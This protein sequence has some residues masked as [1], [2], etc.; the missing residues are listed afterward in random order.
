MGQENIDKPNDGVAWR[1][2]SDF[3]SALTVG[4][5]WN[6]RQRSLFL[7]SPHHLHQTGDNMGLREFLRIP[8]IKINRRVRSKAR[9][10]VSSIGGPS[11]ENQVVPRPAVSAPDLGIGGSNLPTPSPLTSTG[12]ELKGMQTDVSIRVCLT[13]LFFHV[14]H[15]TFRFRSISIRFQRRAKQ[16]IGIF[17]PH[18]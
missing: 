11:D 10:E 1:E 9:S 16:A 18:R 2:D 5:E 8:K 4:P 17:K 12:Q 14:I 6:E 15:R 7:L 13:T 3:F